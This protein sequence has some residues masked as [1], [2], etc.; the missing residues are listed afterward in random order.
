MRLI[1]LSLVLFSLQA[2]HA[3]PRI[4]PL[5]RTYSFSDL[6]AGI[7][8]PVT[9]VV[10]DRSGRPLY[11]LECHNGQ[12]DADRPMSFSGDFHCGLFALEEGTGHSANLL[13]TDEPA[14]QGSDWLNRGRM[15]GVQLR[16]PCASY[17]EYGP[18]RQFRLRKM[19]LT[20]RFRNPA[21]R[22]SR[23]DSGLALKGFT[24]DVSIRPD[25]D[26]TSATAARVSVKRPPRSCG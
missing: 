8:T 23:S 14:E 19:A 6:G 17:A 22:K 26:A 4:I 11:R 3:W 20:L 18:I 2:P 1:Y 12:Y 7:D 25:P 10:E 24:V 13:A 15:L 21:W 9:M 16:Q 5:E